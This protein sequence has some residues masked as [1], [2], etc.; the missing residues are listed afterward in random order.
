[1]RRTVHSGVAYNRQTERETHTQVEGEGVAVVVVIVVCITRARIRGTPRP[2]RDRVSQISSAALFV[3]VRCCVLLVAAAPL[4]VFFL[5][6]NLFVCM[7][8]SAATEKR[9]LRKGDN[10]HKIAA[11]R[12]RR[13]R[14]AHWRFVCDGWRLSGTNFCVCERICVLQPHALVAVPLLCFR[15]RVGH[16]GRIHPR[17]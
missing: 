11:T 4:H 10:S 5:Y 7:R 3:R 1:M 8:V 13:Q 14:L 15:G 16:F 6:F 17:M 9:L 2:F 12:R